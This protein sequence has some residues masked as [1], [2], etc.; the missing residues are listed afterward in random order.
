MDSHVIEGRVLAAGLKDRL[1]TEVGELAGDGI[2]PGL[3][4]VLVGANYAAEVYERR[5]HR[6]ADE[7]GYYCTREA[8]PGHAEEADVVAAVGK[9]N[10]DPR[11]SGILV[12]R[13]LP[14]HVSEAAVYRM[15]DPLKDIEA[16]HPVNAGLLALGRP[17]YV[18]STPASCFHILDSYLTMSGRNPAEFYSRSSIVVVGRSNNVGKP[19]VSLGFA[20]NAT[21]IS[22]DEHAY[23]AG[24]LREYTLRADAL[25]VAAGAPGLIDGDYVREGV[26]A[27]DVG[28][29]PVEDPR[30][31]E[32][33][34]V[35][36]LDF[37]SVAAKAESITPVPGGVGP[38]TDVW[39]L[40]NAAFAA[41]LAAGRK[42][43]QPPE[44]DHGVV[45]EAMRAGHGIL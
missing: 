25:I 18:P 13:P 6:L 40:R 3:A 22:C 16:V 44:Q 8:L 23:N 32:T 39:L 29:N 30:T 21:V 42:R 38:V 35:G 43:V 12:L 41:R 28:I 19:A 1:A 10:A 9:L 15:L 20:R 37:D 5:V 4:T 27:I 7:L 45:P 34:L 33:R 36:D 11:V 2:R 14:D 17:R 24:R 26:I 31:G